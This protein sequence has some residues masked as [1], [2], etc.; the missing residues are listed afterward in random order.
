MREGVR[1]RER[2]GTEEVRE[3]IEKRDKVI[4]KRGGKYKRGIKRGERE[5]EEVREEGEEKEKRYWEIN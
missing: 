4:R 5:R 1:E 2:N 3:G